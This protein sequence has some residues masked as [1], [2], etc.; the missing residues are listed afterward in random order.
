MSSESLARAEV[1]PSGIDQRVYLS[2][3][4]WPQFEAFLAMRGDDP[5]VRIAYRDGELEIMAPS[6]SHEKIKTRL[7]A[8]LEAWLIEKDIEFDG[9]GSWTLRNASTKRGL[10][11]DECYA[12]G[13]PSDES[14]APDLALEVVW[15]SG[16]LD[17][18]DIYRGLGVRE[19]WR[20]RAGAIEV[21]VLGAN[22]YE[23]R[24]R[25]E[26]LPELDLGLLCRFVDSP[27][28]SR[29]V[30]DFLASLRPD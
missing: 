23:P 4:T 25:S 22:G 12:I 27:S 17:K 18:L 21:Y 1:D 6:R 26:L 14:T 5:R 29:A 20:W 15:T 24:Q 8:L 9:I 7:A 10:E 19:V 13:R 28:Q 16:G 3:V 30:R 11:P 2:G